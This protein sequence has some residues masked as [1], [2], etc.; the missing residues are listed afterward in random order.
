MNASKKHATLT[1]MFHV[2]GVLS[3]VAC[4]NFL[5]H[6]SLFP[7]LGQFADRHNPYASNLYGMVAWAPHLSTILC[8]R[9]FEII[10]LCNYR[11]QSLRAW[12]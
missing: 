2:A 9:C 12:H 7:A 3:R 5:F 4:V 1:R 8:L 6:T 11:I 10:F